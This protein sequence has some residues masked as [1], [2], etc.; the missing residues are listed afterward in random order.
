M[1]KQF[2]LYLGKNM[3]TTSKKSRETL[4]KKLAGKK[5]PVKRE[6]ELKP[7]LFS[8][9]KN[10]KK[11]RLTTSAKNTDL[12]GKEGDALKKV[13]KKSKRVTKTTDTVNDLKEPP[14]EVALDTKTL[15]I[16]TEIS[17]TEP[18]TSSSIKQE[19]KATKKSNNTKKLI[20]QN[21][22][23]IKSEEV[24]QEP[25]EDKWEPQN[26]KHILD[27]IRIMR[28]KDNAPV[29]TMGCHKCAD[30]NADEKTQRFHKLVAL[31]LSSQT[32]DET[33]YHAMLRLREHSLTPKSISEMKLNVLE[34]ILH[35]VS[36]Y[37]N[38]AKYLQQTSKVL[39]DKYNSDIPDN[40]KELV[41]LPGVGP[42]MAHI[43]MATAWH[44]TTGIGVDV[45]VH[46]ICNRLK[47]LPRPT[48]E[49]EQT[50][51]ALE[52]WLPRD[53][54]REVNHLLVGF[55][56][57]TCT[58]VKPKCLECLNCSICPEAP[59]VNPSKKSEKKT[60]NAQVS[61]LC[62]KATFKKKKMHV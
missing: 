59:K 16:K 57:T 48:K 20:S 60:E 31:M 15:S 33:T 37:K 51:V 6:V 17:D 26:W 10:N 22:D 40:I 11:T 13:I 29:D 50:R 24:K 39:I 45:H 2:I 5:V 9:V 3:S 32:K 35:P 47:W 36:F 53:L 52:Q 7:E 18:S 44:Q 28:S 55:G 42:K 43:C 30:E 34:N 1:F 62:D 19:N 8:E 23:D 61:S 25:G 41:A 56:Q 21:N 58:P 46:R 12:S 54:W 14:L 49:P 27:N 4:A 38:K